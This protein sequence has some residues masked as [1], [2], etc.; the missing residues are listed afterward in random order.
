MSASSAVAR[1]LGQVTFSFSLNAPAPLL[2]LFPGAAAAWG[3]TFPGLYT[4]FLQGICEEAESIA[5]RVPDGHRE[6]W[7]RPVGCKAECQHWHGKQSFS[8]LQR[9]TELAWL[10]PAMCMQNAHW[11][12]PGWLVPAEDL[13]QLHWSASHSASALQAP[14]HASY[15]SSGTAL[16]QEHPFCPYLISGV[17]L[18][19][20]PVGIWYLVQG[21]LHANTMKL[22]TPS[23]IFYFRF[24]TPLQF[25]LHNYFHSRLYQQL[26]WN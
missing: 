10:N 23:C 3:L 24:P 20:A 18:A 15:Q 8:F 21:W 22:C 4:P 26:F 9:L 12:Q 7:V 17:S 6:K 2:L 13:L 16:W 25:T 14:W 11:H 19:C 5:V 1:R